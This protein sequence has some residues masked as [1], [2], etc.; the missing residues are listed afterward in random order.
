MEDDVMLG[1]MNGARKRGRPR[2]RW[3][4]TL[5]GYVSGATISNMSRDA[6][7]R[8]GCRGAIKAVARGQMRLDGT[9]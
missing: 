9:M 3:L 4:D 7:D 1:R 2:Q 5:N 8:A 6:K